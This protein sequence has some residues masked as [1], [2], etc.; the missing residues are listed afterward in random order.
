MRP[1]AS[2]ALPLDVIGWIPHHLLSS[3]VLHRLLTREPPA[4]REIPC[5]SPPTTPWLPSPTSWPVCLSVCLS[6]RRLSLVSLFAPSLLLPSF[7]DFRRLSR[8]CQLFRLRIAS[9]SIHVTLSFPCLY[10]PYSQFVAQA[11]LRVWL[12]EWSMLQHD[13][14]ADNYTKPVSPAV[15]STSRCTIQPVLSR[16][17]G[18]AACFDRF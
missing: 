1:S 6:G 11:C 17:C 7:L 18:C 2:A 9:L 12:V 4:W 15:G 16:L 3:S 5:C 10:V 14:P 13:S 8:F